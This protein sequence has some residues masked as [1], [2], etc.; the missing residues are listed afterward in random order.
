MSSPFHQENA[1]SRQRLEALVR[2]L[3]PDD[4]ARATPDGWTVAA[5]LGHLAFH[6]QR[7]LALARRWKAHGVDESPLDSHAINEAAKPLCL[8]LEPRAAVALCLASAEAVDAEME[9][10]TDALLAEIQASG[11][12]F[13]PNRSLHR[14]GHLDEIQRLVGR[15]K[16][17]SIA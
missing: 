5:L 10:L 15:G 8:A 9:T 14:N 2:S 6:D 11:S 3:A 1:A 13:R 16:D 7:H 4:F 17:A 12:W